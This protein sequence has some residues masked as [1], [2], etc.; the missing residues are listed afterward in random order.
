MLCWC[1]LGFVHSPS[2][3]ELG[4]SSR[5][6]WSLVAWMVVCVGSVL[7][8][9]QMNYACFC[10]PPTWWSYLV[11]WSLVLGFVLL[12]YDPYFSPCIDTQAW[13]AWWLC[14]CM[15]LLLLPSTLELCALICW[16]LS[17]G[18]CSGLVCCCPYLVLSLVL[19]KHKCV[20]TWFC[21]NWILCHLLTV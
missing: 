18:V 17:P 9:E 6:P 5:S 20:V 11:D 21:P 16:N 7:A 12:L 2:P 4:W 8:Q 19:D 15:A 10:F 14:F 1:R 3:P 13:H